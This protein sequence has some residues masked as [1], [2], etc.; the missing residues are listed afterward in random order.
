MDFP[1]LG[2]KMCTS[3]TLRWSYAIK[4]PDSFVCYCSIIFCTWYLIFLLMTAGA[5]PISHVHT[6]R[7]PL[8]REHQ[9]FWRMS[10]LSDVLAGAQKPIVVFSYGGCPYCRMVEKALDQASMPYQ[11]RYCDTSGSSGWA[12]DVTVLSALAML[13]L[14]HTREISHMY[15]W[16]SVGRMMPFWDPERTALS[17][18]PI[19]ALLE[20]RSQDKRYPGDIGK[21][22]SHGLIM[23]A[24]WQIIWLLMMLARVSYSLMW[25]H[26]L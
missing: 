14:N 13:S 16:W 12:N 3:A 1:I 7:A 26:L 9:C 4:F 2:Q 19:D 15:F 18:Q 6:H 8:T 21:R 20:C 22:V 24:K 5:L 17:R 23:Y 25:D 11:V 10:S